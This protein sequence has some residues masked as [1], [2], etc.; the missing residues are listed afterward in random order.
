[1]GADGGYIV[2]PGVGVFEVDDAPGEGAGDDPIETAADG[3]A[4]AVLGILG[5]PGA[6]HGIVAEGAVAIVPFIEE[7]RSQREVVHF[8]GHFSAAKHELAEGRKTAGRQRCIAETA[9]VEKGVRADVGLRLMHDQ[10]AADF[11][12]D[13][14]GGIDARRAGSAATDARAPAEE[15]FVI[16]KGSQF[17]VRLFGMR[18]GEV[19]PGRFPGIL[20]VHER[21]IA[22]TVLIILEELFA[23]F[24]V[25]AKK[26]Q[27]SFADPGRTEG[28]EVGK[29][30]AGIQEAARQDNDGAVIGFVLDVHDDVAVGHVFREHG[31]ETE[32]G[33]VDKGDE[34]GRSVE[35][36]VADG[37]FA[38]GTDF[39]LGVPD[40]AIGHRPQHADPIFAAIAPLD[41]AILGVILTL[42]E[43]EDGTFDGMPQVGGHEVIAVTPAAEFGNGAQVIIE[44]RTIQG[45][46][47]ARFGGEVKS[48][49]DPCEEKGFTGSRPPTEAAA[50]LG[51]VLRIGVDAGI[52]GLLVIVKSSG[53]KCRGQSKRIEGVRGISQ[54]IRRGKGSKPRLIDG[55]KELRLG[56]KN[57]A[58]A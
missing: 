11:G 19:H 34:A 42:D 32:S 28:H 38:D 25:G 23:D 18:M 53:G 52:H 26:I 47:G 39:P 13:L 51:L 15:R 43:A 1:L 58:R 48:V 4:G 9:A 56:V 12:D 36:D 22:Y 46:A 10:T 50:V 3:D 20:H 5:G 49:H 54:G 16:R 6:A 33:S 14:E 17:D 27:A 8:L 37:S 31:A 7:L 55:L 35:H 29:G 41:E 21:L 57:V 44:P 45:I 2:H 24:V 40:S 30:P